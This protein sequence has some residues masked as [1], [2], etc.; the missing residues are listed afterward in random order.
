MQG[1]AFVRVLTLRV[2]A[3]AAM[4]EDQFLLSL[5]SY[6][7]TIPDELTAHILAT[8][9]YQCPD[10]RLTKLISLSAQRFV[11]EIASDALQYYK[12]RQQAP[13][14]IKE[15]RNL[16]GK[17]RK[18]VLTSEDLSA[19]LK[20]FGVHVSKPEYFADSLH[21]PSSSAQAKYKSEAPNEES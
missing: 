15:R 12:L 18:V 6:T 14:A 5:D 17:E 7:P 16:M 11:S 2:D 13:A 1:L 21:V 19:A 8:T 9:G 3:K 20:E 10:P 4:T